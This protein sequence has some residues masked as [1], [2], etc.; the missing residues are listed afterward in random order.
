MTKLS[1]NLAVNLVILYNTVTSFTQRD[2]Y[3][4]LTCLAVF[5]FWRWV[6]TQQWDNLCLFKA[7]QSRSSHNICYF[8]TVVRYLFLFICKL[9]SEIRVFYLS[10]QIFVNFILLLHYIS[11]RNI[12]S[13]TPHHLS[14][15]RVSGFDERLVS[16][17]NLSESFRC[18]HLAWGSEK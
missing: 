15:F 6:Q 18:F 11:K 8:R 3:T 17:L 14:H 4:A 13:C 7:K 10:I 16:L 12:A 5:T 2:T 1:G 9:K